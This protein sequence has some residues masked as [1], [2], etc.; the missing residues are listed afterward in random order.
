MGVWP[1][2]LSEG[3]DM[4][5]TEES[6][7]ESEAAHD[8]GGEGSAPTD[9]DVHGAVMDWKEGDA[10]PTNGTATPEEGE[11]LD[12]VDLSECGAEYV[13]EIA[14]E[15]NRAFTGPALDE[16]HATKRVKKQIQEQFDLPEWVNLN[17][18]LAVRKSEY[19]R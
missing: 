17:A 8:T 3:Y 6:R 14:V 9:E 13:V 1:L 10:T 15:G 18:H 4:A 7:P 12:D 16:D 19:E 11:A 2:R 5:Q